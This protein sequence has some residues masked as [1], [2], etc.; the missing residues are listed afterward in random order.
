MIAGADN[1]T[2]HLSSKSCDP[3]F[4]TWMFEQKH[5]AK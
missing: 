5:L 1:A 4:L 2:L 3:D